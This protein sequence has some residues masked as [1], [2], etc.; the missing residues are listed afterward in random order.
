MVLDLKLLKARGLFIYIRKN[1]ICSIYYNKRNNGWYKQWAIWEWRGNDHGGLG[2]LKRRGIWAESPRKARFRLCRRSRSFRRGEIS[3]GDQDW[4]KKKKR[5]QI[6]VPGMQ[7]WWRG[8]SFHTVNHLILFVSFLT[9]LP[10][11]N[12]LMDFDLRVRR[13][14]SPPHLELSLTHGPSNHSVC[15]YS[16][17]I[18]GLPFWSF[19]KVRGHLL[20]APSAPQMKGRHV[21]CGSIPA[22]PSLHLLCP[23]EQPVGHSWWLTFLQ[24]AWPFAFSPILLW[25]LPAPPAVQVLL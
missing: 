17:C 20:C 14:S 2:K 4:K 13:R 19:I 9:I 15:F 1:T 24:G 21:L 22:S 10:Y 7:A 25:K 3:G 11:Y 12:F 16:P 6:R 8:H 5:M 23:F 18:H